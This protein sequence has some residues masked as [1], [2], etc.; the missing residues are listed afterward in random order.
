ML[1][2]GNRAISFESV[3]SLDIFVLKYARGLTIAAEMDS[4]F[5]NDTFPWALQSLVELPH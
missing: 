3:S 5:Q 1:R 4:V 2:S